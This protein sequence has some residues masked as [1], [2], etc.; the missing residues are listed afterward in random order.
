LELLD[1]GLLVGV[2][3]VEGLE[4]VVDVHP[5]ARPRLVLV[6]GRDLRGLGRQVPNVADAGLHDVAAAEVARDRLGLRRRLDDDEFVSSAPCGVLHAVS[7]T[8][9]LGWHVFPYVSPRVHASTPRRAVSVA[10]TS[11]LTDSARCPL[12]HPGPRG[13]PRSGPPPLRE[14]RCPQSVRVNALA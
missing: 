11:T 5:Q 14:E 9:L 1:L 13:G 12:A 7:G 10:Q 3:D 6:A 2:D 4:V 8:A